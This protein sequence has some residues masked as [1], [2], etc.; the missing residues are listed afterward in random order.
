MTSVLLPDVFGDF[1]VDHKS[2][3][4]KELLAG[5]DGGDRM[6]EYAV[7]GFDG[8][9]VCIAGMVQ[10]SRAVP[11]RLPSITW[12]FERPNTKVCPTSER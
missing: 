5:L 4:D 11:P 7:A 10:E 3:I 2:V 8:F 1:P 12:P 6:N 9:A